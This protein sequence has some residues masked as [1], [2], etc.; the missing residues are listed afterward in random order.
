[1]KITWIANVT[2]SVDDSWISDGFDLTSERLEEIISSN[3]IP[4]A[5]N[6]E[7][8]VEVKIITKP[9]IKVIKALQA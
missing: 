8:Q 4:Y 9:D 5:Y 6:Y 2:I 7:K 1:M 3:I